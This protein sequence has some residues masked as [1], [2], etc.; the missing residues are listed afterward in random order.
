MTGDINVIVGA[1]PSPEPE[2]IM[3]NLNNKPSTIA[4]SH[5]ETTNSQPIPSQSHSLL[6]ASWPCSFVCVRSFVRNKNP[7]QEPGWPLASPLPTDLASG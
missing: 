3:Y 4:G 2:A 6:A 1:E 7:K 5:K